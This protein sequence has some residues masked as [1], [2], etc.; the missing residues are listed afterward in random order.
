[1]VQ[2]AGERRGPDR[3]RVATVLVVDDS[4]TVRRILRRDLEAAG[5]R[6]NE[7]A[8]GEQGLM[9]CRVDRPDLVLLDV[10]MPVLDGLATMERMQ[11]DPHLRWLPV[12]FLTARIAGGE[13]ARGL[14]LGAH[15]Y[16]KKP[17]ESSELI[18]RV[19]TAMRL[20]ARHD[21]LQ[22]RA[23]ELDA[24]SNTDPLTGLP[25]RRHL[26][27]VVEGLLGSR[28][29]DLEVGVVM[30][31]ID[32]FKK[33][34]DDHGHLVGD[35]VLAT[36][37]ARMRRATQALETLVRWGGEEFVALV[38]EADREAVVDLAERLRSAVA[39]TPLAVGTT[40][41]LVV[42]VSAGG[43]VGTLGDL[44]T[45]LAHA[46]TALYTAKQGGRNRVEVT[47]EPAA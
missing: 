28:G 25:N 47:G 19:S 42:T 8:D 15:D 39:V 24:L 2:P 35:A 10:D 33:V 6:V 9:S 11:E 4:S 37:A 21:E 29:P 36:V 45:L 44:R 20:A 5:Y 41:T 3:V 16:L 18:A 30:V 17:C 12:L 13:V 32:H 1:M 26:E 14:D 46:D 27:Q 40:E 22:R 38:T 34:N 43:A 31:D 7:A 23:R